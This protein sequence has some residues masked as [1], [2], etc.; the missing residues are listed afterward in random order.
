MMSAK[1]EWCELD[2]GGNFYYTPSGRFGFCG[3]GIMESGWVLVR[4]A[5]VR[6]QMSDEYVKGASCDV[7]SCIGASVYIFDCLRDAG[8]SPH[9]ATFWW[10]EIEE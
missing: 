10:P 7:P 1:T 2:D 5:K 6:I 9:E 4:G 8:M 3:Q